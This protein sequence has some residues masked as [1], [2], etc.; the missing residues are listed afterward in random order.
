MV[1]CK[2]TNL[3]HQKWSHFGL[4]DIGSVTWPVKRLSKYV[5]SNLSVRPPYSDD[6]MWDNITYLPGNPTPWLGH[7]HTKASICCPET[8]VAVLL[9]LISINLL[10]NTMPRLGCGH[11]QVD[12]KRKWLS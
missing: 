3:G 5:E 9:L 4:Q 6:E 2:D 10:N 12:H 8:E 11:T 1:L 7:G